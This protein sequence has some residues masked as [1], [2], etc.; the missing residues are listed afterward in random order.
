MIPPRNFNFTNQSISI[1]GIMYG[2]YTIRTVQIQCT[3][4]R[5]NNFTRG[6]KISDKFFVNKK[7]SKNL[8]WSD[9]WNLKNVGI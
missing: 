5:D 3:Q 8:G 2:Q 6:N 7:N 1:P 4:G 9:F